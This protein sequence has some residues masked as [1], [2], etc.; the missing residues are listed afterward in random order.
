M[1]TNPA[2]VWRRSSHSGSNNNCVEILTPPPRG[3]APVRDSK[4]P[5]GPVIYFRAD[6]WSSFVGAI[7]RGEIPTSITDICRP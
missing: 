6:A 7:R 2:R 1:S 4:D 3:F 5:D